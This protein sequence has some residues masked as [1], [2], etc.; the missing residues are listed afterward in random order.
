MKHY[1]SIFFA[2][3][4]SVSL[5][6][7]EPVLQ[8]NPARP[9]AGMFAGLEIV[10][11][12]DTPVVNK[13]PEVKGIRWLPGHSSQKQFVRI[14]NGQKKVTISSTLAFTAEEPGEYTIPSFKIR[15][16]ENSYET[17]PLTFKVSTAP[18]LRQADGTK[19]GGKAFFSVLELPDTAADAKIYVGEELPLDY[20]VCISRNIPYNVSLSQT[21][22]F[23][24][25]GG[26][27]LHFRDY[28]K[29]NPRRPNFEDIDQI[30]Q[31][32]DGQ[33][34]TIMR[35]RTKFRPLAAGPLKITAQCTLEFTKDDWG[36]F[37]TPA[38]ERTL[39]TVL[40]PERTVLPLPEAPAGDPPGCGLVGTWNID[41]QLSDGPF[42]VGD[43]LTLK[44]RISGTGAAETFQAPALD[45]PGFRTYPAELKIS[46]DGT[47]CLVSYTLIPIREGKLPLRF[48]VSTFDPAAGCYK[49]FVFERT[50]EAQKA[51]APL[52]GGTAR[53]FVDASGGASG[54]AVQESAKNTRLQEILYPHK[55]LSKHIMLPL[56]KNQITLACVFLL[57]GL[58]I[59]LI[60]MYCAFQAEVCGNDPSILR[61]K[62]ALKQKKKLL[63]AIREAKPEDLPALSGQLS[64]YLNSVLDLPP[65]A[66]L[67]EAAAT[68]NEEKTA[69]LE[70]ALKELAN[71]AWMPDLSRSFT[72]KMK[73]DLLKGIAKFVVLLLCSGAA[74][75]MPGLHAEELHSSDEAL[76]EYDK[77]N[78][79]AALRYYAAELNRTPAMI[80]PS[81]LYN[82]GNCFYQ[83]GD[84]ARALVCY[85]RAQRLAP[86]DSDILQNL[87][88]TRRKLILPEKYRVEHP[89]DLLPFFRDM[90]RAD[91][92]LVLAAAALFLCFAGLGLRALR[93]KYWKGV[94]G[95]GMT[96]FCLSITAMAFQYGIQYDPA[97]AIIIHRNTPMYSLPSE[98]TGKVSLQLKEGTEIRVEETRLGWARVRIGTEEGWIRKADMLPL[99]N[100]SMADLTTVIQP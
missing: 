30:R 35:F 84:L 9:T 36:F 52:P 61:R 48:A 67:S 43:P 45:L 59:L 16:G 91:E 4:F 50:V 14:V 68:F 55:D 6:P 22:S 64:E 41:A 88:L 85:E 69:D 19:S 42:R 49:P 97:A 33:E 12:E 71:A 89:G 38:G 32:I 78:F 13:L 7:S 53:T 79:A 99:W 18:E 96:V 23:E 87:N 5:R 98:Q 44:I 10:S 94:L 28:R 27:H 92:W 58:V 25:G 73:N 54:E 15:T 24:T 40:E 11:D 2:L 34:Y 1:L 3:I 26:V 76:N 74:F 95:T 75:A 86:R 29:K 17:K 8:L 90:L 60:A 93:R 72:E 46:D 47:D 100:E 82:M 70:H 77:G 21:P 83:T 80:S 39:K 62:A 65:G 20:L 31:K 51:P 66:G 81:V 37:S 63:K 56:W 57:S